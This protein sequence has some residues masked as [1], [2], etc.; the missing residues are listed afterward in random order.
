M[1]VPPRT[2]NGA[3]NV[4]QSVDESSFPDDQI[5][6]L[7]IVVR[8]PGTASPTQSRFPVPPPHSFSSG[9]VDAYEAAGGTVASANRSSLA[10]RGFQ[11]LSEK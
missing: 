4:R 11:S 10:N 3:F 2:Q 1:V 7:V 6:N 9:S 8:K 5:E